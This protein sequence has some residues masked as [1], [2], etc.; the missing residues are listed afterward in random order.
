MPHP[1][2]DF[3]ESFSLFVIKATGQEHREQHELS[4]NVKVKYHVELT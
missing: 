2:P 1:L 3:H 4:G